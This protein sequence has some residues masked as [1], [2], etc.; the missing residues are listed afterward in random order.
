MSPIKSWTLCCSQQNGCRANKSTKTQQTAVNI[1]LDAL[2]FCACVCLWEVREQCIFHR[3][4][5][6]RTSLSMRKYFSAFTLQISA[7][8][9]RGRGVKSR[10]ESRAGREAIRL[11]Y[12][13]RG[14]MLPLCYQPC[15]C[16]SGHLPKLLWGLIP[17][18][19]AQQTSSTAHYRV[20]TW[21]GNECLKGGQIFSL[22]MHVQVYFLKSNDEINWFTVKWCAWPNLEA[23]K[24]RSI[25][26]VLVCL[27]R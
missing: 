6:I 3:C 1:N 17:I 22:R 2:S 18:T 10:S 16:T 27:F 8:D 26:P 25:L 14:L 15:M 13:Q 4:F 11:V 24:R 21:R 12:E 19:N 5:L 23:N 9:K 7:R 20:L